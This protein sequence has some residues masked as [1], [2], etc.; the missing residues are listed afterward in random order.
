ML[1][2][3]HVFVDVEIR[4]QSQGPGASEGASMGPRLCRRGNILGTVTEIDFTLELQWG[5]VFVDVEIVFFQPKLWR[6]ARGFNGATS[7]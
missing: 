2:W 4:S 1:Q 5:H 3:G 6:Y 7:L